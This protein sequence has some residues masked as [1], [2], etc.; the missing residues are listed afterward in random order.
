MSEVSTIDL[1]NQDALIAAYEEHNDIA[2]VAKLFDITKKDLILFLHQKSRL[3][4][5]ETQPK[6]WTEQQQEVGQIL[7]I[8]GVDPSN[9]GM[10]IG[11]RA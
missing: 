4:L 5:G 11:K 9:I 2:A 7:W 3:Y 1:E 10:I 8:S 6:G